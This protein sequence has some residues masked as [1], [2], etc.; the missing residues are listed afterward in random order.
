MV[1]DH[2]TPRPCG[3][4]RNGIKVGVFTSCHFFEL[5]E[6]NIV[7]NENGACWQKQFLFVMNSLTR[8]KY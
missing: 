8:L 4:K 1:V 7:S 5:W 6:A 3:I 2:M